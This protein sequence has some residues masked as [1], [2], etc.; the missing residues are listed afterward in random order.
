MKG[1]FELSSL[2]SP[3]QSL[4]WLGQRQ[5]RGQATSPC[6]PTCGVSPVSPPF[7]ELTTAVTM[8]CGADQGHVTREQ[9]RVVGLGFD[10]RLNIFS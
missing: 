9:T 7:P 3:G 2:E 6:L 1:F 8:R 10:E 4:A 5:R